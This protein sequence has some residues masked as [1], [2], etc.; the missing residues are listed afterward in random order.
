MTN[1]ANTH[2]PADQQRRVRAAVYA[3]VH[4]LRGRRG[5]GNEWDLCDL[6]IQA[7]ILDRWEAILVEHLVD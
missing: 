5:L 2:V 7:E 4:D 3:I 1:V 6:D